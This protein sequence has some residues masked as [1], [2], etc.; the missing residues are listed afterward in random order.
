MANEIEWTTYDRDVA[1]KIQGVLESTASGY[2]LKY[3]STEHPLDG[4][5]TSW[6]FTFRQNVLMEAIA[7]GRVVAK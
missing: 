7:Q 6:K 3:S 1:D 2:T 5:T 4:A